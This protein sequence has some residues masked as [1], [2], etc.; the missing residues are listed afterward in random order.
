[1]SIPKNLKEEADKKEILVRPYN[2]IYKL[3]DDVKKEINNKLPSLD[4][5][6][7]IGM[8]KKEKE[9]RARATS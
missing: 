9:V 1:M 5:E 8:K 2:V 3:I 7:V 6:E 4:A